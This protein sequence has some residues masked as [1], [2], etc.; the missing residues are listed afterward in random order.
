METALE[1]AREMK[2]KVRVKRA[3]LMFV[4][5]R[6]HN[7]YVEDVGNFYIGGKIALHKIAMLID[8]PGR[9][10]VVVRFVSPNEESHSV[11]PGED[12]LLSEPCI[13][14]SKDLN[15][16]IR[17]DR[18]DLVEDQWRPVVDN[19]VMDGDGKPIPASLCEVIPSFK[20]YLSADGAA[21]V[22]VIAAVCSSTSPVVSL[23]E[24]PSI[25]ANQAIPFV[26]PPAPNEDETILLASGHPSSSSVD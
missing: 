14:P 19:S 23:A 22:G 20:R 24:L 4:N 17:L 3:Y 13:L 9:G 1:M 26:E 11:A 25:S 18:V 2:E 16:Q 12:L 21:F 8:R 10:G 15:L 6:E 5:G 7:I